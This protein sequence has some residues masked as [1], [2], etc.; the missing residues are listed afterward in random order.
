MSFTDLYFH[1]TFAIRCG[2]TKAWQ[3]PCFPLLFNTK[4]SRCSPN[5]R[6]FASCS[7]TAYIE[8]RQ[9]INAVTSFIDASQVY[10]SDVKLFNSLATQK[11]LF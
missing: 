6:S 9:Q 3:F 8:E 11:G 7:T 5:G 2:T 1:H 4:D 10:G